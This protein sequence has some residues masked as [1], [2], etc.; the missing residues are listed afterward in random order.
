MCERTPLLW[1]SRYDIS[2]A[3]EMVRCGESMQT[4]SPATLLTNGL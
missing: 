2:G 4:E 1:N 3:Q